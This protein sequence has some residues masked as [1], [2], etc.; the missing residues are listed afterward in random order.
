MLAHARELDRKA[1]NF[2][3]SNEGKPV[4]EALKTMKHS[5]GYHYT[6]TIIRDAVRS[7]IA[8]PSKKNA[9]IIEENLNRAGF[10]E[11][12]EAW[13]KPGSMQ[14]PTPQQPQVWGSPFM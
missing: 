9:H 10:Y 6:E 4:V 2:M 3:A 12:L 13:Q 11:A 8:N 5:S 1:K 14:T 7:R